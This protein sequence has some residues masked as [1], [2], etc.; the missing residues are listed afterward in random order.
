MNEANKYSNQKSSSVWIILHKCL[1]Y[2]KK[3]FNTKRDTN[4]SS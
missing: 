2:K 3:Q 1:F 4:S